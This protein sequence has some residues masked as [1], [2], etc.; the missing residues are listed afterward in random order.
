MRST[1]EFVGL[2]T[3]S[4]GHFTKLGVGRLVNNF[5]LPGFQKMKRPKR[6]NGNI[7]KVFRSSTTSVVSQWLR[8]P[9]HPLWSLPVQKSVSTWPIF[10]NPLSKQ[11][12]WRSHENRFGPW[13]VQHLPCI[14][15]LVAFETSPK[16][17]MGDLHFLH[18]R[19][20]ISNM[21]TFL[22]DMCRATNWRTSAVKLKVMTLASAISRR[23]R[24][25]LA[26]PHCVLTTQRGCHSKGQQ[27]GVS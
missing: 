23:L 1:K 20:L 21:S 25:S 19:G 4:D 5:M 13:D 7:G 11:P 17:H 27:H 10:Q 6:K 26:T 16:H 24:T 3:C 9:V 12:S 14:R 18:D 2:R 8:S 15:S 22:G